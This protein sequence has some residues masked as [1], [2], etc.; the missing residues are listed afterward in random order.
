MNKKEILEKEKLVFPNDR[1]IIFKTK[2][3]VC[4]LFGIKAVK[5]GF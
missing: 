5:R 1:N 2:Q 4:N 3:D